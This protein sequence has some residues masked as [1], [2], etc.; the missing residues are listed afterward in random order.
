MDDIDSLAPYGVGNQKPTF[1]FKNLEVIELRHF[2]KEKNH[3]EMRLKRS[4]GEIKAYGYFMGAHSFEKKVGLIEIGK[5][6]SLIGQLEREV[7]GPRKNIK[8][9]IVDVI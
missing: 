9:R 7:F 5:T 1:L 3:L 6:I 8:V 4:D 2:G